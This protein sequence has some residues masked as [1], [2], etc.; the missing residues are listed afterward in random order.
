MKVLHITNAYP[1]EEYPSYGIFIKEQVQSLSALGIRQNVL[2]INARRNGNHE[3][4]KAAG[5]IRTSLNEFKPDILH[6]HHQFSMIPM[7]LAR[8]AHPVVLSLLGDVNERS[9]VNRVIARM[10]YP[11]AD[12]IIIKS[13]IPSTP[14]WVYLPNGVDMDLFFPLDR[15]EA[16]ERLGLD[17]ENTYILF[18]AANLDNPIKRY[19][20]FLRT[21]ERLRA[22]S[23]LRIEPLVMSGVPRDLAAYYFNSAS[24]MLLTSEHEGSPNAVK[25]AMACNIPVVSTSVGNVSLLGTPEDG[26]FVSSDASPEA[27]ASHCVRALRIDTANGRSLLESQGLSSAEVSNKLRAIY[28]GLL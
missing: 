11:R 20:L 15:K 6:F 27:L 10:A 4:I 1:Y 12:R 2:F 19:D 14:G 28:S 16:Q 26:V 17:T 22:V 21:I 25:E 7:M 18:V 9:L 5:R 3:Y 24:L 8:K 23:D 13:H